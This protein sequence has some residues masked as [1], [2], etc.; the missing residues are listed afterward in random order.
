MGTTA[1]DLDSN[2]NYARNVKVY[3]DIE[4]NLNFQPL[5]AQ[6]TSLLTI[7]PKNA[8]SSKSERG[9]NFSVDC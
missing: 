7:Y 9:A 8:S 1:E 3:R 4:R 5:P 2:R 6:R